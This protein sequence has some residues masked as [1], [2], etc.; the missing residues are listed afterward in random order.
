MAVR[1][2]RR[3]RLRAKSA[4]PVTVL[5]VALELRAAGWVLICASGAR[6]AGGDWGDLNISAHRF[7][8]A[9]PVPP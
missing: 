8:P 1:D 7:D 3:L 6:H 4:A 2:G 9:S 5:P